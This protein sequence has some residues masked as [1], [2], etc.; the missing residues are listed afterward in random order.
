MK[1]TRI[2][3]IFLYIENLQKPQNTLSK[4]FL[5]YYNLG[6][7]KKVHKRKKREEKKSKNAAFPFTSIP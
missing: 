3:R 6:R 4:I 7:K 5:N 2:F 1:R